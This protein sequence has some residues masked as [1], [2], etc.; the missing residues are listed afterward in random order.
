MA[1]FVAVVTPL[2][3]LLALKSVTLSILDTS[4]CRRSLSTIRSETAAAMN[5]DGMAV[6][7]VSYRLDVAA[8]SIVSET[9]L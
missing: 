6:Y 2:P 5:D 7:G 4:S 8:R 3:P 9:K 1:S